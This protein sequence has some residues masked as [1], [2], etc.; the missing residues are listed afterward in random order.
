[1][2]DIVLLQV[3]VGFLKGLKDKEKDHPLGILT[4]IVKEVIL[5]IW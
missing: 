4:G 5:R 1:M 3:V 2:F